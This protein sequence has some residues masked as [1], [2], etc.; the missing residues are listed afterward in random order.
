[1]KASKRLN[2]EDPLIP[3]W[4]EVG[5]RLVDFPVSDKG[6]KQ[7]SDKPILEQHRHLSHLLMIY[8][9]YLANIEQEGMREVLLKSMQQSLALNSSDHNAAMVQTHAVPIATALGEGEHALRGLAFH[10]ADLLSNGLWACAGNP[11]IESTLS[12]ANN[13]QE[14]LLQSWCDPAKDEPGVIRVFPALPAAWKDVEFRDLRA[15]PAFLLSAKRVGGQTQWVK[16]KSLAGE[17]CKIKPGFNGPAG[18]EGARAVILKQHT[19]GLY[20]I[21]LCK[22]E[23]VVLVPVQR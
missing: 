13:I 9:L 2:I 8:P 19:P 6:F 12:L 10:Q 11:C 14:M 18:A 4:R 22:G 1:L 7:G 20:E 21:I 16:I 23:E 3:R 5:T 17:P 15:D